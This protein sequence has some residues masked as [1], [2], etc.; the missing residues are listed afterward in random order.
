[1]RLNFKLLKQEI[2]KTA[3]LAL[4]I[5]IGQLGHVLTGVADYTMLGH[6]NPT[7]MAGATF[8]TS[9]FFPF[10]ILGLGFA[11]GLTPLV[12]K[13]CGAR[14]SIKLLNLFKTGFKINFLIGLVL[15]A[16]LLFIGAHL[17]G[18]NQPPKVVE[19]CEKYFLLISISIIPIMLFSALKQFLEGLQNTITPMV[20]SLVGNL[21]NVFLNYLLIFDHGSYGGLG[22]EGAGWATLIARSFMVIVF[23][24]FYFWRISL[25]SILFSV[26]QDFFQF[27]H[28]RDILNIGLPISTYMF[29]EV[30]AFSAATFMMGWISEAH[31]AAHQA[32]LS[33]A[34][35][36]FV[37]LMGVGNSG[38]I[39]SATYV[40]QRDV[41]KLKFVLL[42][43]VVIALI[44]S[45]LSAFLFLFFNTELPS[46][47]VDSKEIEIV[48]FSSNLLIYAALFQFSDGL[49]VVFQGLLQGI[50]D[51]KIPSIIAVA[52][53]WVVGIPL[54]YLLAFHTSIG[55]SGIWIGLSVGLTISAIFQI[56]R[57]AYSLKKMLVATL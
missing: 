10:M 22:I 37:V 1:M 52:S 35:I 4:P 43:V 27:I 23:L 33:L 7:E 39:R 5:S 55:Y 17:N 42:S 13:A 29:F 28:L 31:M 50:G 20:I 16:I 19:V 12:A 30:T 47:F 24:G 11:L 41:E 8:S 9:V 40:G 57:Y 51:V 14:D 46:L 36:S 48:F 18:F 6:T 56:I 21:L 45:S 54:G 25:R 38:S 44:I 49:Q 15:F 53:Y 2:K 34:S 3:Y 26:F 32:A